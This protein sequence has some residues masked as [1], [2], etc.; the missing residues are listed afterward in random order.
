MAECRHHQTTDRIHFFITEFGAESVVKVFNCGER[1]HRKGVF[2]QLA[3]VFLLFVVEF[4][5]DVADDLFQNIFN[6]D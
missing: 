2:A 4:I 3:N 1:F 5:F 6:G